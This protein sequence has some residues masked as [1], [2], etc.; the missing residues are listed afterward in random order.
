[1]AMLKA[2]ILFTSQ[3]VAGRVEK[4]NVIREFG[5]VGLETCG[6]VWVRLGKFKYFAGLVGLG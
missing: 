2:N 4:I 5:R 3:S 1:M 6:L